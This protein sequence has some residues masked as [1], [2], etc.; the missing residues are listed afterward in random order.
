MASSRT[1]NLHIQATGDSH[2]PIKFY[3]VFKSHRSQAACL[4]KS[5]FHLAIKYKVNPTLD[6]VWYRNNPLGESEIRKFMTRAAKQ[7]KL[8]VSD[9]KKLANHTVR[10]TSTGRLIDN[11]VPESLIIQ[12]SGHWRV[13]SLSSYKAPSFSYQR[14]MSHYLSHSTQ[15]QKKNLQLHIHLQLVYSHL[16]HLDLDLF[17]TL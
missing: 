7:A 8:D 11:N 4:E 5:S 9:D 16:R 6:V 15:A 1:F 14:Q 17:S 3:K 12:H 2:C 10:K 13:E